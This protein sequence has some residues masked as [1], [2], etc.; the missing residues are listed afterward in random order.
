MLSRSEELTA[1]NAEG[2]GEKKIRLVFSL[3]P[4]AF[5]AVSSDNYRLMMSFTVI[6]LGII[7]S[8]CS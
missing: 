7:G 6:P 3:R 8:T 1:E 4:S 2:R 5:S